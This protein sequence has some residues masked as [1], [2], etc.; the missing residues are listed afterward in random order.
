MNEQENTTQQ[1][2][3]A[4]EFDAVSVPD[5]DVTDERK[6]A[7]RVFEAIGLFFLEVIKIAI[8]AGVT[9]GLVRYFIF[10]PFYVKG[11]SMESTFFE[12]EYLI[13]DEITYRFRD[14]VRGEV[15]VFRSP[16][17]PDDFYLKRLI[18]LPGERVK[19]EENKIIIYNNEHPQGLVLDEPYLDLGTVTEGKESVTL[20]PNQFY[21]LGDNREQSF[22]SRRFGPI[23]DDAIV[24]RAWLRGFPF[25]RIGL[26]EEPIYN[27]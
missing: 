19:V 18:A 26:F 25:N 7:F 9:I 2:V 14:P 15:L 20:G 11:Q 8:L 21:V 27:L 10:K 6:R 17:K 16:T 4:E 3:D 23:D 13:I 1:D 24:G 22:D 12:K 5:L